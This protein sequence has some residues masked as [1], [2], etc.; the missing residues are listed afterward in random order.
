MA[1]RRRNR[2]STFEDLVEIAA[3]LPWWLALLLAF[4]AYVVIHRYAVMDVPTVAVL[5][6]MGDMVSKQLIKTLATFGQYIVPVAFALGTLTSFI[7]R[8][9]RAKLH[10]GVADQPTVNALNGMSWR[11]FEMLVGEAFRRRGYAVSE[12]GEGADGGVDLVLTRGGE[13]YLVQCKQWKAFKVGVNIVR[14]LYGV[15]AARGAAGGFVVT[16]GVFTQDAIQFATGRNIDLINGAQ[17]HA[18]IRSAR[19]P[20]PASANIPAA[21]VPP[22]PALVAKSANSSPDCP[23]CGKPM[24]PRKAKQG[25]NAGQSFWGC[26]TFPACRGIRSA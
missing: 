4:V 1:Q 15:M 26:S 17:L 19:Q 7:G 20:Q 10:D 24:V 23:K 12:T 5:G 14:E 16:S 9:R 18:M 25:Q 22:E 8:R 21:S 13:T 2:N 11:E 6:Q 3:L